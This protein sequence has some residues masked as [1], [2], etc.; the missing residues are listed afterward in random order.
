MRCFMRIGVFDSGLGGV[1]VL[2][3]LIKKYPNNAYIYFGDTKN[4]PYGDKSKDELIE[5]SCRAI[6]FLLTKN[7]DI[8]IIACGTISSICYHDLKKKYHIPIYDIISPTINYLV[9]SSLNK[10]GVIGTSKTIESKI[11]NIKNKEV[12]ME[13]TPSFVPI[14]ENNQI[15]DQEE[16]IIN[17][18]APFKN[19]DILVLG[20]THYPLIKPLCEKI[21]I[22]TLDMGEVL[23]NSIELDNKDTYFCELYFSLVSVNLITNINNI[24]KDDYQ[25]YL[26]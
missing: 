17:K 24:L 12:L 5:L 25:I 14:I 23:S 16:E 3:S 20:C 8:I 18:I 2:S 22:K 13:A 11:F 10:I 4:L 15:K 1:N 6:D 21:G 26:K 9:D 7:V 19:Y